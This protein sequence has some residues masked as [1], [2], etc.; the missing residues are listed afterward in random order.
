MTRIVGVP[1]LGM[2]VTLELSEG[3]ARF[4]DGLLGY[5]GRALINA[6]YEKLGT[7]YIKPY[8]DVGLEF[9]TQAR[10]QLGIAL[11]RIDRARKAFDG[12]EAKPAATPAERSSET[13]TP[14]APPEDHTA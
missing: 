11:S 5:G 9:C 4:L 7:H 2:V 6:A 14:G 3:E 12:N 10:T 13:P 8:E 1:K